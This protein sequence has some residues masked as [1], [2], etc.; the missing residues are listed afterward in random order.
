MNIFLLK[1]GPEIRSYTSPDYAPYLEN[2]LVLYLNNYQSKHLK[3]YQKKFA[4]DIVSVDNKYIKPNNFLY[5][6]I[7]KTFYFIKR[8]YVLS[9]GEKQ[10]SHDGKLEDISSKNI[11]FS[12]LLYFPYYF[13]NELYQ[14]LSLRAASK[15]DRLLEY[16]NI[17]KIF[18]AGYEKSYLH[19]L[20]SL[21]KNNPECQIIFILHSEKDLY[22][23]SYIPNI[24]DEY[25]LWQKSD[26]DYLKNT[27]PFFQCIVK[28]VGVPRFK[29]LDNYLG[30]SCIAKKKTQHF[31]VIYV[32]SHPNIVKNESELIE[33]LINITDSMGLA[34]DW[35]IRLNPMN[36][37]IESFQ[38]LCRD[39]VFISLPNWEWSTD[40]FFN[41]P[42][43]QSEEKF[44]DL[45]QQSDIFVGSISTVALEACIAKKKYIALTFD[46]DGESM[47]LNRLLNSQIYDRYRKYGQIIT[48]STKEEFGAQLMEE[49]R[50]LKS[51]DFFEPLRK[52]LLGYE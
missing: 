11:F 21:K 50:N 6:F 52:E 45:I 3:D 23:D 36:D 31:R 44:Y 24:C 10:Y 28:I 2:S 35:Y 7:E 8:R 20:A 27:F 1:H 39:H 22:I 43:F 9:R 26:A 29:I 41:M 49:L 48:C 15:A 4:F 37:E 40:R 46:N 19:I 51:D 14:Y 25:H 5:R 18:V 34:V 42:S 13:L 30:T 33:T 38:R 47:K 16:K 12:L 17:N 32:C